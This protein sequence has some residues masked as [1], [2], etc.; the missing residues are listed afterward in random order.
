LSRITPASYS[1]KSGDNPTPV[2]AISAYIVGKIHG[3]F[4]V[5]KISPPGMPPWSI[6][7][8]NRSYVALPAITARKAAQIKPV[9]QE[10]RPAGRFPTGRAI[11][12]RSICG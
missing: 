6:P 2:P 8:D 11:K 4:D 12:K 1:G 7:S 3:L 10:N 5:G 9:R